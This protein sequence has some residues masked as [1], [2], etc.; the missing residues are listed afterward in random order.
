MPLDD[1]I[2][3]LSDAILQEVRGPVTTALQHLMGDLMR[4]AAEDRDAAVQQ[5][6]T[7]ADAAHATALQAR[8]AEAAQAHEAAL[9]A[10]REASAQQQAAALEAQR[11]QL[12]G[13]HEAALEAARTQTAGEHEAAVAELHTQLAQ[14]RDAHEAA[15]R[16]VGEHEASV[17]EL[18]TQLAQIHEAHEAALRVIGEHEASVA[19]LRTQLAQTHEA[20]QVALQTAREEADQAHTATLEEFQRHAAAERDQAVA[21]TREELTRDHEQ[22]IASLREEAAAERDRAIQTAREELARE[23][24][25]LMAGLR[26]AEGEPNS[27]AIR[28]TAEVAGAA[29]LTAALTEAEH[30]KSEAEAHAA[31][32]Q[33]ALDTALSN[34]HAAEATERMAAAHV[35]EA[36]ADE[37]QTE[38]ACSDRVLEAFRRLDA[39]HTLSGVLDILAEQVEAEAGRVA[40]LVVDD[41]QLRPWHVTKID[42]A[43]ASTVTLPLD[44]GGLMARVVASGVPASTADTGLTL[45]IPGFS[46]LPSVGRVGLLLP[47][48]VGGRVVAVVYADDL[49]EQPPAVPSNWP[50]V[51]EILA[52]HAG[53]RLELLTISHA[54]ALANRVQQDQRTLAAAESGPSPLTD[55]RREEDS[56]RRYARLLIA[57]IKLYNESAVEQGREHRDLL[58]RLGADVERARRLYKDKIPAAVRQRTNCFDEEVVRTLAGGDAGLLGQTP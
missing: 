12:T 54:S 27:G 9:D 50:E 32:L 16:A 51:A 6:R 40:V 3:Q 13:E 42:R 47:V 20:H 30:R 56:A 34:L 53:Q 8:D 2:Q 1:R 55:E 25:S 57:E 43:S 48:T 44:P 29:A 24:E 46:G 49:G 22:R 11:A 17:G 23:H 15:L 14:T 35:V 31:E 28:T 58:R 39:A 10:L 18:R 26:Q 19:E 41:Q 7:D 21:T 5:A 36:H 37:R 52:R 4:L 45:D 38:L 33:R